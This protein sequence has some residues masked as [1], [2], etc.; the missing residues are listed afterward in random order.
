VLSPCEESGIGFVPLSPL[1]Q[2]LLTGKIDVSTQ[3]ERTDFRVSFPRFTPEA[4]QANLAQK[5]WIVPIPGTTKIRRLEE[6]IGST[7]LE[8][9][10]MRQHPKFQSKASACPNPSFA[11]LIARDSMSAFGATNHSTACALLFY[12]SSCSLPD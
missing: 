11:C 5:I 10:S 4:R 3:F 8:L 6:N 12:R 1:G 7:S 9:T 2:R